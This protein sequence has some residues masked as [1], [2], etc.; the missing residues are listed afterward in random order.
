MKTI[1]QMINPETS[2]IPS[3]CKYKIYMVDLDVDRAWNLVDASRNIHPSM[4]RNYWSI[5]QERIHILNK[6]EK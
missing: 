6:K 5:R 1:G 2:G 4:R 3:D